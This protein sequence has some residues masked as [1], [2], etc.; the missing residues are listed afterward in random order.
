M[1]NSSRVPVDELIA[2][3][4]VSMDFRTMIFK[5]MMTKHFQGRTRFQMA[6]RFAISQVC[7]NCVKVTLNMSNTVFQKQ[8]RTGRGVARP[9]KPVDDRRFSFYQGRTPR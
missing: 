7:V 6:V 1:D 9:Q 8:L 3:S 2:M 4:R 5:L